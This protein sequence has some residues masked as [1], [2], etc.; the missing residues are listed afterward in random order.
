MNSTDVSTKVMAETNQLFL[1]LPNGTFPSSQSGGFN[2]LGVLCGFPEGAGSGGG[3]FPHMGT[4]GR[5]HQAPLL[6]LSWRQR[7]K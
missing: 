5:K 6:I 4:N 1:N 3:P 7:A 2:Q